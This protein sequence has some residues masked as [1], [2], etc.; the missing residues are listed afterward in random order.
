MCLA[1][2]RELAMPVVPTVHVA[3]ARFHPPG[4]THPNP[5][6]MKVKAAA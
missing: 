4:Q 5:L 6:G 3:Q 2:L 1:L